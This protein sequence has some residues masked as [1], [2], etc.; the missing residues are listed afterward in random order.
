MGVATFGIV[1]HD[2]AGYICST[3]LREVIDKQIKFKTPNDLRQYLAETY[4][5]NKT[6]YYEAMDAETAELTAAIKRYEVEAKPYDNDSPK[7]LIPLAIQRRRGDGT[8]YKDD[9]T[10][11]NV[12]NCRY[13]TVSD[14]LLSDAKYIA[15][16]YKRQREY[17][18]QTEGEPVRETYDEYLY[19]DQSITSP[20]DIVARLIELGYDDYE[21]E[22][23]K[24]LKTEAAHIL[25][26]V[27]STQK[28]EI[29]KR[30]LDSSALIVVTKADVRLKFSIEYDVE[31]KGSNGVEVDIDD[32]IPTQL[33]YSDRAIL[34][35]KLQAID[36]NSANKNNEIKEQNNG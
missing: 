18:R 4:D 14:S 22:A 16:A 6:L 20:I 27:F 28:M 29:I 11:I 30:M 26:Y 8:Q 32:V 34:K 12:L 13:L 19:D 24:A 35:E 10:L 9:K 7:Y 33:N 21:Q 36:D 17:Y 25:V 1:Q 2:D 3:I 15:I 31:S 5:A 23:R